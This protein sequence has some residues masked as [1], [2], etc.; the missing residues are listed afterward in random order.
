MIVGVSS[1]LSGLAAVRFALTEARRRGVPLWAVRAWHL[2]SS[3]RAR[4]SWDFQ[5]TV[6]DQCGRLVQETF[7]QAVGQSAREVGASIRVPSGKASYVLQDYATEPG[8]LI[9]LG[10]ARRRWWGGDVVR[11]TVKGAVCPVIVVPPPEL[12]RAGSK[13]IL[14]A[15]L[16]RFLS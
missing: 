3:S 1:S 5:R 10:A 8:D 16:D 15:E 6:A 2:E 9:V 4:P 12:A 11:S 13:R 7:R 14:V